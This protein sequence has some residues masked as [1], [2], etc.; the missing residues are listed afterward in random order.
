MALSKAQVR[1][2]YDLFDV[3]GT[4]RISRED[5]ELA[6][7]GLGFDLPRSQITTLVRSVDKDNDGYV[8]RDEFVAL[9][10]S[11]MPAEGSNE[12][13][14]QAYKLFDSE[15]KGRI[16]AADFRAAAANGTNEEGK[17]VYAIAEKDIQAI[18]QCGEYP[19]KG[20][21]FSEWKHMMLSL[22]TGSSRVA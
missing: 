17:P 1:D 6:F 15:Q 10:D 19:E 4:K 22:G 3:D 14:W 5:A 8:T 12:E 18:L 7:R 20:L 11:N 13:I 16:T 9:V 2:A 21:A